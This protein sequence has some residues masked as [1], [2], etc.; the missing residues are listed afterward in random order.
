M[1]RR[2]LINS[3]RYYD[4]RPRKSGVGIVLDVILD[5]T[6]ERV[7]D[8]GLGN[9]ETKKTGLIGAVIVRG[10]EDTTTP[11]KDLIPIRP[12]DQNIVNLPLIGESVEIIYIGTQKFYK[13]MSAP[14]LNRGTAVVN[15][16]KDVNTASSNDVDDSSNYREAS[17]TGISSQSGGGDRD[18]ELGEYFEESK[19]NSLKLYEGDKII[20][21]RFGQSIRFSG[22]NNTEN[23]LAPT[24]LIRNRQSDKSLEEL[25]EGS[26]TEEDV[27]FDGSTIAITSGEYLLDFIPGTEDTPIDTQPVYQEPPEE[28]NG[29]QIL[30][31][32]GRIIL[33]S[34]ES[35]MMFISK[36]NMQFIT[37][38]EI[39]ID[40]GLSGAKIDLNGEYRTTTN[41]NDMFFLGG[42]GRIFLNVDGSEEEP[43]VRGN[44]L[45][46]LLEQLIDEINKQ[47]FNTPAGPTSP[48]PTNAAKFNEIK[49]KLNEFL[50]TQN[51]TE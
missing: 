28:L 1:S 40:A 10:A 47:I 34:K 36:G 18:T 44:T 7:S 12:Y 45:L 24:I 14:N 39:T 3:S 30:L 35:E 48:G 26:Q 27:S 23:V 22:F 20:Q 9:E 4:A 6:H 46:E 43:L 37:D 41:D 38:G 29:D 32:S 11:D 50:S 51:F 31:N 49:G 33:S 16:N 8:T 19:V 42:S 2:G 17:S 25:K 5:D 13:R 15:K 21:S